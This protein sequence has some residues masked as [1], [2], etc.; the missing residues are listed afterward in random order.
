MKNTLAENML[1]FGVK[2]LHKAD[3]KK[4][5]EISTLNEGF[6]DPN[7]KQLVYALNFK[8]ANA[9]NK[10]MNANFGQSPVSSKNEDF[11]A[12][13]R[14]LTNLIRIAHAFG[15]QLP[16]PQTSNAITGLAT[17][18]QKF[19]NPITEFIR[20]YPMIGGEIKD[21]DQLFS[22]VLSPK[23]IGKGGFWM[24]PNATDTSKYN[25]Q[26]YIDWIN[27]NIRNVRGSTTIQKP[28]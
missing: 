24:I 16:T 28:A 3:V 10:Y 5:Q 20:L 26:V 21:M 6:Q 12:Y 7:N 15:M 2:N 1:R 4:I 25:Y 23:N 18:I 11:N 14:Q 8:D 9:L 19:R 27:T 17:N 13:I 22:V